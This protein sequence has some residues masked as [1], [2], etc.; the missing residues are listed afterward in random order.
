MDYALAENIDSGLEIVDK[1][2]V[3]FGYTQRLTMGGLGAS[4]G[5]DLIIP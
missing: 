2:A 3:E 4:T 5:F 1:A